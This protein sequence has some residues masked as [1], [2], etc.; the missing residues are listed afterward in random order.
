M[1]A[2]L[3][4]AHRV[5]TAI[6]RASLLFG[7]Q[8]RRGEGNGLSSSDSSGPALHSL[9]PPP[10]SKTHLALQH[11]VASPPPRPHAGVKASGEDFLA[12]MKAV[13]RWPRYRP[14]ADAH[15]NDAA[16]NQARSI[17]SGTALLQDS[18]STLALPIAEHPLL[19]HGYNVL[20]HY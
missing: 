10:A 9:P 12:G 4:S 6:Q 11:V 1:M 3:D 13:G 2:S 7:S 8:G 16:G 18:S 14:L 5:A 17:S 20:H 15:G 19:V